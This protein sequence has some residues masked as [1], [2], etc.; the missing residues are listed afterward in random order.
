[1]A[2]DGALPFWLV[3]VPPDQWPATCPDY[4]EECGEKDRGIIGT[5]DEA[6][7][8]LTW[9]DVRELVS[10]TGQVPFLPP[11]PRPAHCS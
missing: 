3:N 7:R 8:V 4:L 11:L 5:P 10:T 6:Y 1:M 2:H 9:A